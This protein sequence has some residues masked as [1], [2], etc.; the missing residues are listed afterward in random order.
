MAAQVDPFARDAREF[1]RCIEERR[2][3]ADDRQDAAMMRRIGTAVENARSS[4]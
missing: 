2:C 1:K 4:K 3:I